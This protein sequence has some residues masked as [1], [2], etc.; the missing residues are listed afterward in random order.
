MPQGLNALTDRLI[1]GCAA[2]NR[3]DVGN[4]KSALPLR[5]EVEYDVARGGVAMHIG[6][7]GSPPS[8]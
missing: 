5:I 4:L 2:Q 1:H 6:D 8:H 3:N 7:H